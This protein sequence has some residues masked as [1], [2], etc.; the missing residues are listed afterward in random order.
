MIVD[1]VDNG[2]GIDPLRR[3]SPVRWDAEQAATSI[4]HQPPPI[5]AP[6]RRFDPEWRFV[7]Y[8]AI[9]AVAIDDRELRTAAAEP[10]LQQACKH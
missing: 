9:A 3:A 10:A 6:V 4:E 1:D 8:L 2:A 5:G 7:D